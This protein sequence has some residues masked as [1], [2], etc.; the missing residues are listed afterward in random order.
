MRN[1]K[2]QYWRQQ[3]VAVANTAELDIIRARIAEVDAGKTVDHEDVR[4]WLLSWGTDHEQ[5]PPKCE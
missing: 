4:Q 1:Y 3:S 2:L 5:Q